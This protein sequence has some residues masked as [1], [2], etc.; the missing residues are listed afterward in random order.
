MN[1]IQEGLIPSKYFKKSTERLVSANGSQ[2]KIKY[3]LNNS[4]VLHD[5]VCAIYQRVDYCK[6]HKFICNIWLVNKMAFKSLII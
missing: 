5:N 3:E 2:M 6:D 4:H 1:C